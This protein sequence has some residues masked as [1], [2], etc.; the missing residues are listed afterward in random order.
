MTLSD[1]LRTFPLF[2]PLSKSDFDLLLND[3]QEIPYKKG[4]YIFREGD[5]TE[6]FHIVKDGTVKCVKSSPDGR[7]MTLKVLTPGDLFCCE[8]SVFEGSAHPG[9]AK[10]LD[11]ATVL[12]IPKARYLEILRRN[13]EMAIEVIQYLGERLREAQDNAKG[14]VF[15]RAERRMA[16]I[17]LSLANKGGQPDPDGIRLQ[18]KLT[19]RDLADMA[20]LT[21]ETAT[22]I[23]GRFKTENIVL[24]KAKKIVICNLDALKALAHPPGE[25][26]GETPLPPVFHQIQKQKT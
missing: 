24:G 3:V 9:C 6:W 13:P 26:S 8:A 22:R 1:L 25:F 12:K 15:H 7:D 19:R 17:L 21:V 4:E 5:P 14:L 16:S 11:G 2:A 18:A 10:V 23:M 20:G